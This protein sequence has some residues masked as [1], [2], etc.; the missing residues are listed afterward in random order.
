VL[1]G[2]AGRPRQACGFGGTL[3]PGLAVAGQ[4]HVGRHA[5]QDVQ[6][7]ER[8]GVSR[9]K[10]DG[11]ICGPV[12]PVSGFQVTTTSPVSSTRRPSSSS[13]AQPG[14]C[15]GACTA[16][17]RPGTASVSPWP[18]VDTSRTGIILVAPRRASDSEVR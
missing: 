17:G 5:I 1:L 11:M 13:A 6:R 16:R 15:P 7:P 2:G 10:A 12:R 9:L 14:V 8:L 18:K 3:G 4:Q